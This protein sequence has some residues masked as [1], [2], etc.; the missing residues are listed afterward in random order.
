MHVVEPSIDETLL[1]KEINAE[2]GKEFKIV[3][4]YRGG[5]IAKAQFSNVSLYKKY[6]SQICADDTVVI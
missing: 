3:I 2:V 4:P 5:P 6:F 1:P